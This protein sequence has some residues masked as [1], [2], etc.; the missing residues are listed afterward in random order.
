M[1][2]KPTH[3]EE[4]KSRILAAVGRGFRKHGFGSIGVDGLAK[5]AEVT[6]GAFYGHFASKADAFMQAVVEGMAQLRTG[7]EG[8]QTEYGKEWLEPFVDFY[9]GFKRTCDLGEACA[10]QALTPDVI[11]AGAALHES[12][13]AQLLQV[14]EAV[15]KGLPPGDALS[16][17]DRAWG[18]MLLLAA[19]VTTA[20]AV[21]N[22]KLAE[23]IAAA[24]RAAALLI[25][26]G[27]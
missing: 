21:N 6:S 15:A 20:R 18:L 9:L 2:Y 7:I 8:F 22:Q 10:F 11:R 24:A 27:R 12:Y 14:I 3:R 26:K 23:N 13:E 17:K 4:S 16:P 5:E 19:G 1:R 25:A